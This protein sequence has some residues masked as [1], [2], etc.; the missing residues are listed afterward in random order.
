M[1]FVDL[2]G[3]YPCFGMTARMHT[4]KLIHTLSIY[5]S[6]AEARPRQ[7]TG[8]VIEMVHSCQG[9]TCMTCFAKLNWEHRLMH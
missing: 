8:V 3:E 5:L 9:S 6:T 4:V 1:T 2:S 7:D